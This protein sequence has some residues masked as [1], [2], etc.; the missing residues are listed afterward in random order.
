MR[1]LYQLIC[2][3]G[4]FIWYLLGDNSYSYNNLFNVLVVLCVILI[5]NF[6][7]IKKKDF[8]L[9]KH[10]TLFLIGY[11]VV[12]FQYYIDIILN[13]T[14]GY[15][16]YIVV[17]RS[18]VV[19]SALISLIGLSS[20]FLGYD[21]LKIRLPVNN[22]RTD[23]LGKVPVIFLEILNFILLISYFYFANPLY[24]VGN[25]GLVELGS[26]A[27]Y[28]VLIMEVVSVSVFILKIVNY[29]GDLE[30]TI[31]GFVKSFGL[32]FNLQI[33]VYL[34][35]VLVSGD[36]GPIM[37][38][39]FLYLISYI[40]LSNKKISSFK[41]ISLMVLGGVMVTLL[42]YIRAVNKKSDA[43]FI[44]KVQ[45]LIEKDEV[46]N[47]FGTVSFSPFT[48]ELASS[49]RCLHHSVSEV[50]NNH[51]FLNGR[52]QFQQLTSIIPFVSNINPLIFDDMDKKYYGS[53]NFVTWIN[54]G[55]HPYSG[56]G[57]TIAADFYLDFGVWG[58]FIGM[59]FVGGIVKF[60]ESVLTG[61]IKNYQL[62]SLS[63]V[64]FCNSVYISRATF[65]VNI[66]LIAWVIF[67]LWGL[68]KVFKN[69]DSLSHS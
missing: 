59:F 32:F 61:G 58:V 65:L 14:N 29:K 40:V 28:L 54:Q 35:S 64:L 55:D 30:L 6:I 19:K 15:N 57:T 25:Y 2:L 39:V 62:L 68:S 9:L 49:V 60:C 13:N 53:A 47:R 41:F 17:E 1:V 26:V 4:L 22:G 67:L 52:F 3:I 5:I 69:E 12:H 66:K 27:E 18:V 50:P 23:L 63:M 10:S 8:T 21:L 7:L 38:F 46:E 37:F 51:E 33:F 56:D 44:E 31:W 43:S 36:R 20:F 48:Q 45:Y 34:F 24:F 42:G 16:L 11:L